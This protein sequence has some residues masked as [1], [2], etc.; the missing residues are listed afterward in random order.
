MV[1]WVMGGRTVGAWVTGAG[2]C[3]GGG[4]VGAEVG[5]GVGAEV[6]LD[7]GAG[8]AAAV[9]ADVGAGVAL[10]VGAGVAGASVGTTPETVARAGPV[11]LIFWFP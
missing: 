1:G 6:G 9:G 3:V 7:V 11:N 8:V 4:T 10:A 5:A 2:A